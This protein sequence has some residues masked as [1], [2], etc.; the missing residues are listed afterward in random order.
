[1]CLCGRKILNLQ[2]KSDCKSACMPMIRGEIILE[3]HIF[4]SHSTDSSLAIWLDYWKHLP[5]FVYSLKKTTTKSCLNAPICHFSVNCF[6][7][8]LKIGAIIFL[9]HSRAS[10]RRC[11]KLQKIRY[12]EKMARWLSFITLH[13]LLSSQMETCDVKAFPHAQHV[14]FSI[15]LADLTRC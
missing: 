2:L 11:L 14:E 9:P 7:S 4:N 3:W 10:R 13:L 15:G 8:R 12:K 5:V 1:M 6:H